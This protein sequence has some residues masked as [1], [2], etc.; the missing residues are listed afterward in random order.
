MVELYYED[1]TMRPLDILIGFNRIYARM[2]VP[3]LL[4]GSEQI[5]TT[6]VTPLILSRKSLRSILYDHLFNQHDVGRDY[7]NIGQGELNRLREFYRSHEE[8]I[9]GL[10]QKH[11]NL[12][13][14]AYTPDSNGIPDGRPN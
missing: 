8:T 13:Y 3:T 10:S 4:E 5:Y 6:L 12:V 9:I 14:A 11:E 2:G 7:K 1:A